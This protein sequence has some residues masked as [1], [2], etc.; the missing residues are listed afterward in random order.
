VVFDTVGTEVN[1]RNIGVD[2]S[3][4][5]LVAGRPIREPIV[6]MGPFVMNTQEEIEQTMRDFKLGQN[7]FEKAKTWKSE[8][9]KKEQAGRREK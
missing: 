4:F 7:G 9:L 3:H 2:E 6:Q 8:Y 1:F 5:I